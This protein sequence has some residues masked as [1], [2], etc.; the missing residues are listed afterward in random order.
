M[1]NKWR[2]EEVL[3]M[4]CHLLGDHYKCVK[5]GD[6]WH[7]YFKPKGWTS[8]GNNVSKASCFNTVWGAREACEKHFKAF[9]IDVNEN[10][11]ISK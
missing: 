5:C 4:R 1:K 7:A 2:I 10:L 9:G 3:Y 6:K 11:R 8:F